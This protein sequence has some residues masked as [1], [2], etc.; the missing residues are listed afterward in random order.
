M[1]RLFEETAINHMKLNNRFVRSAT[2]ESMANPDGSIT[3]ELTRLTR[4]LA[5][6]GVG[7]IIT[8]YAYISEIG[9]SRPTQTGAHDD[10]MING[11]KEMVKAAHA[12]NGAII[13]QIAHY[14]TY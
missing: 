9:K 13:M 5:E 12:S 14:I 6:G 10:S 4:D 1:S 2:F 7:L 3:P 11:L 8:G